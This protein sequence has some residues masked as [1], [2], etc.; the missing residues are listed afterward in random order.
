MDTCEQEVSKTSSKRSYD[1]M[2]E[3]DLLNREDTMDVN[4]SQS[5]D[6]KQDGIL[7]S[8]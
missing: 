8:V 4:A 5:E 3:T 7:K 6:S 1:T 2:A